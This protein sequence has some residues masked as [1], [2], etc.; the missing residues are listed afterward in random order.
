H[1]PLHHRRNPRG[2]NDERRAISPMD[3]GTANRHRLD[4]DDALRRLRRRSYI[5]G[6]PP[7]PRASIEIDLPTATTPDPHPPRSDHCSKS[8]SPCALPPA[9][10]EAARPSPQTSKS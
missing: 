1:H 4:T 10:A 8:P 3:L 6:D 9:P 7:D 5:S 2:G